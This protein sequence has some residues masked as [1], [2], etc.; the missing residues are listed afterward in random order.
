LAGFTT[1]VANAGGAP[2]ALYL[3]RMGLSV[4]VFIG[5]TAWFFLIVNLVKLPF[6]AGLGLVSGPSLLMNLMLAPAVVLGA[7]LGRVVIVRVR[8]DVFE[9]LVLGLVTVSAL[10]LLR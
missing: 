2:T 7:W 8:P 9:R 4:D 10:L 6:S 1:M 3:L 5:T